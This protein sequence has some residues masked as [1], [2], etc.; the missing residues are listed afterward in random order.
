MEAVR[1]AIARN[2]AIEYDETAQSPFYT[3]FDRPETYSDA[4]E[5]MVW[6]ENA[7]SSDAMLKLV[8][9]YGVDGSGVWNIMKFFPAL[10][11]VM[12]QLYKIRK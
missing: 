3:Y 4:V 10:W 1:R 6:F 8:S 2:A 7:R 11:L 9:E 5:H 12:N